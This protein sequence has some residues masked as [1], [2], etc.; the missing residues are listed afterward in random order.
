VSLNRWVASSH[1]RVAKTWVI[2]SSALALHM[3]VTKYQMLRPLN[4]Y[5]NQHL[6]NQKFLKSSS[7]FLN[8]FL[9]T[10][11]I[12]G[13][14]KKIKFFWFEKFKICSGYFQCRRPLWAIQIIRDILVRGEG[15]R[16][17]S[18]NVTISQKSVTYYFNGHLFASLMFVVVNIRRLEIKYKFLG[19]LPW[20]SASFVFFESKIKDIQRTE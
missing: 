13:V 11:A 10:Y 18:P 7:T 14:C 4:I 17:V 5:L 8:P 16:T 9:W 20:L 1:L 6:S 19:C 15:Y 3:W 2:H 12:S